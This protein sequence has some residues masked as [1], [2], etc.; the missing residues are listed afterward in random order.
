M[1][2]LG[3]HQSVTIR[4]QWEAGITHLHLFGYLRESSSKGYGSLK[5]TERTAGPINSGD[6]VSKC[7]GVVKQC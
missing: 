7:P 1:F 2:G 4:A 6:T 5:D 3:T